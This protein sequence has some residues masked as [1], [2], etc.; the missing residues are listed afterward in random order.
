MVNLVLSL[1]TWLCAAYHSHDITML[2]SPVWKERDA[3]TTRMMSNGFV[4]VVAA[5]TI[6]TK[7]PE[8]SMR[9]NRIVDSFEYKRMQYLLP[10]TAYEDLTSSKRNLHEASYFWAGSNTR[11]A[12]LYEVSKRFRLW[13]MY[14]DLKYLGAD[15]EEKRRYTTHIICSSLNSSR[16]A[17]E[18]KTRNATKTKIELP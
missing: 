14:V 7:D 8:V 18:L 1:L 10:L 13:A 5:Q 2:G 12:C 6:K 11:I 15:T 3:A 4:G 16:L 17:H 9:L